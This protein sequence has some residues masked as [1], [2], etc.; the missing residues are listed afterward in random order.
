MEIRFA[1][2]LRPNL[3]NLYQNQREYT[4]KLI[5]NE[6]RLVLSGLGD[7]KTDPRGDV[8]IRE[9]ALLLDILG[10]VCYLV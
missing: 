7:Y 3:T 5:L 1:T 8:K 10:W 9:D 4:Q 6:V 2:D